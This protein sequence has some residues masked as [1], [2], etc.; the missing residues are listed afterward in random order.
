MFMQ[1]WRGLVQDT[2]CSRHSNMLPILSSLK[3]RCVQWLTS[4]LSKSLQPTVSSGSSK[5]TESCFTWCQTFPR[6]DLGVSIKASQSA[7]MED[8]WRANL[9]PSS[10]LGPLHFSQCS[11]IPAINL[12]FSPF[13]YRCWS[14]YISWAQ[15]PLLFS[16]SGVPTLRYLL[17]RMKEIRLFYKQFCC[18][19]TICFTHFS[20]VS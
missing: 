11:N 19:K 6:Y 20:R 17:Q 4:S 8:N 14:W 7:L 15:R 2:N 5:V 16:L 12:P 18:N 1:S 10:L 9:R 13:F 3:E